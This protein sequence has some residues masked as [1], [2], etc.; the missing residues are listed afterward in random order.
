MN[1]KTLVIIGNGKS[2]KKYDLKKVGEQYDTFGLNGSFLKWMEMDWVPTY[3]LIMAYHP[4]QWGD[5]VEEF[6]SK[7]NSRMIR[8]FLPPDHYTNIDEY[9][10]YRIKPKVCE[11]YVSPNED[12]WA[13]SFE[14]DIALTYQKL[15]KDNNRGSDAARRLME[16]AP[17]RIPT[18]LTV[19]GLVK[20]FK[21]ERIDEEDYLK[22][23]RFESSFMWPIDYNNFFVG[24]S[25]HSAE[26]AVR[27]AY[28]MG[29]K[30][31]YLIGCDNDFVI[32]KGVMSPNSYHDK[33]MFLGQPYEVSEDIKCSLCRTTKGLRASINRGWE[34]L[35]TAMNENNIKDLE[36]INCNPNSN[37]PFFKVDKLPLI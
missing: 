8:V 3:Q 17:Q 23:K 29:Y 21:C 10:I 22:K 30:R 24:P 11:S 5:K 6:L 32:R 20:F 18:D 15:C 34:N 13:D 16:S 26:V 37:I 4:K 19:D 36:I 28:L 35:I 14:C 2:V 12:M 1:V 7:Y 31:I 33:N 27:L 9:N 25:S